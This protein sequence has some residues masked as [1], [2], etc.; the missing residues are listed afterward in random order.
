MI[1]TGMEFL[2]HH[3]LRSS[4]ERFPEKEA[5]VYKDQ[6]L[7]YA[8]VARQT[9]SFAH[10]LQLAGL[11]RFDRIGIY[12]G[13]S[14]AQVLSIFGISLAGGVFV[15]INEALFPNQV[16][17]IAQDCEMTGLITDAAG[18]TNL[19]MVI[20]DIPSL[21]YVVLIDNKTAPS[22]QLPTYVFEE[23]CELSTRHPWSRNRD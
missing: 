15:P 9:T 11:K 7:T 23:L 8:E 14:V 12:T 19:L 20:K 16:A 21:E 1:A 10:G 2:V 6:R 5:L 18:F 4:A 13:P 3:I 22:I 17:H